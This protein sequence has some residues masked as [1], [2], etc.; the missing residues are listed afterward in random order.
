MSWTE[1]TQSILLEA[2]PETR[3]PDRWFLQSIGKQK[4]MLPW[5][6]DARYG[7][8]KVEPTGL[9]TL[10]TCKRKKGIK[11]D[12]KV[13]QLGNW[14]GVDGIHGNGEGCG[15]G[16]FGAGDLEPGLHKLI[17]RCL[18]DTRWRCQVCFITSLDLIFFSLYFSVMAITHVLCFQGGGL[19]HGEFDSGAQM[20]GERE[21]HGST[22]SKS[23]IKG[24]R[25]EIYNLDAVSQ[26]YTVLSLIRS[27]TICLMSH[28]SSKD[29]KMFAHNLFQGFK[30]N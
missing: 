11:E 15:R 28:R 10:V 19:C 27:H 13:F 6:S 21:L 25:D 5:R 8:L 9:L 2:R 26:G 3:R 30:I 24:S 14:K 16:M 18:L 1:K 20:R 29:L 17:L 23:N 12:S 7:T 22:F 4:M